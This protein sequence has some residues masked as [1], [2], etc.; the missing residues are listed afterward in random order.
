MIFIVLLHIVVAKLMYLDKLYSFAYNSRPALS[1]SLI[2]LDFHIAKGKE[3]K[4]ILPFGVASSNML[5]RTFA[6]A[7]MPEMRRVKTVQGK[8]PFTIE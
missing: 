5:E 2:K 8:V 1:L 6:F 7:G 3:V 4:H